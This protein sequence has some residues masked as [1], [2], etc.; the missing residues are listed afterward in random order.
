MEQKEKNN[1]LQSAF[2]TVEFNTSAFIY[3]ELAKISEKIE[4]LIRSKPIKMLF[5]DIVGVFN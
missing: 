4:I 3:Q 2:L 1:L 5:I